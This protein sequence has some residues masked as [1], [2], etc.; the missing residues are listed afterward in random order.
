MERNS[1]FEKS[2]S[3]SDNIIGTSLTNVNE[4][5]FKEEKCRRNCEHQGH[6]KFNVFLMAS[7]LKTHTFKEGIYS[8]TMASKIANSL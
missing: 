4:K 5:K 2:I 3:H 1:Q 7:P 8:L 6:T